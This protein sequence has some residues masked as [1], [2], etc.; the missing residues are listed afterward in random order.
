VSSQR[1][2]SIDDETI[3]TLLRRA[4]PEVFRYLVRLTG[5][6]QRLAED[7]TQDAC[8]ALVR[9]LRRPDADPVATYDTGWLIV[10]ARRRFLDHLRNTQREQRRIELATVDGQTEVEP[11]WSAVEGSGALALL[12]ELPADQ[13]TALVLRYVDDLTVPAVAELLDRSVSATESLLA[14]GRRALAALVEG[15]NHV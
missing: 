1:T 13:R 14:R 10:V 12:A 6:D 9:T 15:V 8:L 2:A 11:D 4:A 5:G 7:L 3:R